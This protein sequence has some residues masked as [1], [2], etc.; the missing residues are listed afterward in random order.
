MMTWLPAIVVIVENNKAQVCSG[1]RSYVENLNAN[2]DEI[3]K[4]IQRIIIRFVKK[5]A[6]LFVAFFRKS[7]FHTTF[8][9]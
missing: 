3:G 6:Y 2:L 9:Q 7:D 1:W 8:F 4:A 5:F